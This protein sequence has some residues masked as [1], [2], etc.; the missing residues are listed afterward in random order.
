MSQERILRSRPSHQPPGTGHQPTGPEPPSPASLPATSRL[1]EH[2]RRTSGG[3]QDRVA[4]EPVNRLRVVAPD[5]ASDCLREAG[6]GEDVSAGRVEVSGQL[7]EL[8]VERVQDT[9]ELGV[10]GGG[11]GFVK[12]TEPTP[13]MALTAT[14]GSDDTT[15]IAAPAAQGN[16]RQPHQG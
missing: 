8:V 14:R 6:E 1:S 15:K 12:L 3:Q 13:S 5:L 9:A 16:R 2:D 10:H 11:V 7:R 4:R